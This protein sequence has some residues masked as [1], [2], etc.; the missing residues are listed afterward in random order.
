MKEKQE[1]GSLK[2]LACNMFC[3]FTN[4]IYT[5]SIRVSCGAFNFCQNAAGKLETQELKRR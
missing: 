4:L 3:D 5:S 1:T 2:G